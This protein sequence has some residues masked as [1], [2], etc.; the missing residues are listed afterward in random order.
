M[1]APSKMLPTSLALSA[2]VLA[3]VACD[4]TTQGPLDDVDLGAH[5]N[6]PAGE[7]PSV[8]DGEQPP[9]SSLSPS[10]GDYRNALNV[11]V[12]EDGAPLCSGELASSTFR[13]GL[14]VC[15]DLAMA[16]EL[17]TSSF[18]SSDP[19]APDGDGGGVGVNG[20]YAASGGA[21]IGG[22]LV[23]AGKV[24][25]V[26]DYTVRGELRAGDGVSTAGSLAIEGD[27]Y[28]DGRI[29]A[30]GMSVDGT[31]HTTEPLS[32]GLFVDAGATAVSDFS[33]AP[34]CGCDDVLDIAAL[35][36]QAAS[37]NDNDAAGLS[38]DALDGFAGQSALTLAP[39][40][41]YLSALRA[42]GD[43]ELRLSGP[44]AIYVDGDISLAGKLEA[45]LETGSAEL[46]LF[47][48]GSISHAGALELGSA[49]APARV[50]TYVGGDGHI[51]I[52]GSA[53]LG[54]ALYAPNARLSAAGDLDFQ[55][56]VLVG[57]VADAGRINV[58]YDADLVDAQDGCE[59]VGDPSDDDGAGD[60][61]DD[62]NDDDVTPVDGDDGNDDD[63]DEPAPGDGAPGTGGLAGDA[64][65][66]FE[67][68]ASPLACVEGT[69]IFIGG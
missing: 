36:A 16:G 48:D 12:S 50:R 39:G 22:A 3:L 57:S 45:V 38:A 49:T 56:A 64:C 41:Y 46:D 8:R 35:V 20:R 24:S 23:V 66:T 31:L 63:G 54:G 5:T 55:G 26:G 47:I 27:A 17:T 13:Y 69:C 25:P 6:D 53:T 43:V 61:G 18:R 11:G 68:C 51:S 28:V 67:D 29:A 58:R 40:R 65:V 21:D 2:L 15:G 1:A 7:G 59:V 34:P 33:I 62:G 10:S 52:A 44:T 37:D 32:L 42:A 9:V 4:P 19:S 60:E 30:I 14:C